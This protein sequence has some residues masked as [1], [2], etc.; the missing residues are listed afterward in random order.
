LGLGSVLCCLGCFMLLF[1]FNV[2][3]FVV[4][5]L[6]SFDS[7]GLFIFMFLL[8]FIIFCSKYPLWPFHSWLP[9]VHVEVST[10]F[11]CILAAIILKCGFFGLFRYLFICFYIYAVWFVGFMDGF[12]FCGLLYCSLFL[13]LFVD[14]KKVI[15]YWS[16]LHTGL[17]IVLLWQNDILF[18]GVCYFCNFSHIFSSAFMFIG[19][20]YLYELYGLRVFIVLCV[21]FGFSLWSNLYLFLCLFNCDFPF[22][23]MFYFELTILVGVF[24]SSVWYILCFSLVNIIIFIITFY[25]FVCLSFFSFTWSLY[26][27]R[28]DVFI[29]IIFIFCCSFVLISLLFLVCYCVI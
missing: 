19:V 28:F 7:V 24:S 22:M 13:F 2:S 6:F 16:I 11:S 17:C 10:E 3:F 21:F 8:F 23:L 18:I 20:G 4:F 1:H 25:S 14:Y 26:Y 12:V 27:F 29:N 9:E 15:S 5:L